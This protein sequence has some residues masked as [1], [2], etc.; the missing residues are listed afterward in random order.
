MR[1]DLVTETSDNIA[2]GFVIG[3]LPPA[4]TQV[5]PRS[6]VTIVTSGGPQLVPVPNVVGMTEAEARDAIVG[7]GFEVGEVSTREDQEVEEGRVIEQIPAPD[8]QAAPGSAIDIVISAGPVALTVP[9]VEGLT[10]EEALD[11]LDAEGFFVDVE[12]EFSPDVE[13]GFATRTDPRAGQLVDAE[14]P[15]V[16]LFISDGPGALRHARPRRDDPIGGGG[17]GGRQRARPPGR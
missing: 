1:V 5:E 7:E 6:L 3:T 11:L 12:R 9:S 16:V 13:E 17:D 2:P 10:E 14:D 15:T 8:D 4:G